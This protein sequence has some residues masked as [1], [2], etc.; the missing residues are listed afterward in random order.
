MT[1]A[2]LDTQVLLWALVGN[3]RLPTSLSERIDSSPASFGVSDACVWEVAI[4]RALGKLTT[5]DDLPDIISNLGFAIVPITRR[6][7]W[8]VR[9]LPFH[10]R[11]PFDRLLIAQALDLQL[12]LISS[13][14]Q[15]AEY[16]VDLTLV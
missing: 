14:E 4:K 16:G 9:N 1:E 15:F 3:D 7:V 2:L 5:P 12:P 10:H 6:Q 8:A 13:D 11:D